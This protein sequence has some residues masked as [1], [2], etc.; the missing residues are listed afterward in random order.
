MEACK[1]PNENR[2]T[3]KGKL[4]LFHTEK[5]VRIFRYSSFEFNENRSEFKYL[6]VCNEKSF[7]LA[8]RIM[9][10]LN[11]PLIVCLA[12]VLEVGANNFGLLFGHVFKKDLIEHRN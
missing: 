4:R 5:I 11:N 3:T 7:D 6:E 1:E 2:P 12:A 9:R 8:K 10:A